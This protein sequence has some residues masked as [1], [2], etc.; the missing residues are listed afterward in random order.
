VRGKE[1]ERGK[2]TNLGEWEGTKLGSRKIWDYY[3][4]DFY[5]NLWSNLGFSHLGFLHLGLFHLGKVHGAVSSCFWMD[6]QMESN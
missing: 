3:V 5:M 4:W 1:T 6:Q 2:G